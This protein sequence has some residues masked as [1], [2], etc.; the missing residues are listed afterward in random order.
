MKTISECTILKWNYSMG[1]WIMWLK[2]NCRNGE[3]DVAFTFYTVVYVCVCV[4]DSVREREKV[5]KTTV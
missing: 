4:C 1:T 3:I 2:F 5:L